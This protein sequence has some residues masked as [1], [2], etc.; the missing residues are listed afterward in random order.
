MKVREF[1]FRR[2]RYAIP[3]IF[4]YDKFSDMYKYPAIV[5][6]ST[7]FFHLNTPTISQISTENKNHILNFLSLQTFINQKYPVPLGISYPLRMSKN[8]RNKYFYSNLLQKMQGLKFLWD[9]YMLKMV[10]FKLNEFKIQH[11]Y[12]YIKLC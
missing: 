11:L 9:F 4:P 3:N 8:F 10:S 1:H 5:V 12:V 6:F 7:L 2:S